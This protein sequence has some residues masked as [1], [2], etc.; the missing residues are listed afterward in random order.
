M[1]SGDHCRTYFTSFLVDHNLPLTAADY[2]SKLCRKIF[3][4]SKITEQYFSARTK[5]TAIVT[6][7]MGPA[8]DSV[9][10]KACATQPFSIMCDSGNDQCDKKYFGIMVQFWEETSGKVVTHFLDMPVCNTANGQT[11]FDALGDALTKR[12][13]PWENVVGFA[14]DSASVMVVKRNSVL[15]RVLQHQL[16]VFS[17]ACVCHLAALSTAAGLKVLPLSIDQLLIDAF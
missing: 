7:A 8:A 15:S 1:Q 17:L 11:L 13:I 3:P 14:S 12:S 4:D 10:N 16:K 9:V 6:H 2:F 5:T